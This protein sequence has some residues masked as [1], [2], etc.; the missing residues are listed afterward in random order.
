[1]LS[2]KEVLLHEEV[3]VFT[4]TIQRVHQTSYMEV[5]RSQL[6]GSHDSDKVD[7][8]KPLIETDTQGERD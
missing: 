6:S 4:R 7:F 3:R 5:L 1:M 8:S 2:V